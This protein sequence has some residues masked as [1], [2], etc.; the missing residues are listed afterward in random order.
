MIKIF[1]VGS[2][3]APNFVCDICAKRIVR[4]AQGVALSSIPS[5]DIGVLSFDELADLSELGDPEEY[6]VYHVHKGA[7]MAALE[8]RFQIER[9]ATGGDGL[10]E[11]VYYLMRNL[12]LTLDDLRRVESDL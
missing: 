2:R 7:C 10:D 6:E 8:Q 4:A 9:Q 5:S 3:F 12:G 1:Y 11:H